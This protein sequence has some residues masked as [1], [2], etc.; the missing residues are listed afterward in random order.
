ME[1]RLGVRENS[2]FDSGAKGRRGAIETY[3]DNQ[4]ESKT[5]SKDKKPKSGE[6]SEFEREENPETEEQSSGL[7][8]S[9]TKDSLEQKDPREDS[10]DP[11]ALTLDRYLNPANRMFGINDGLK[12]NFG[13]SKFDFLPKTGSR[14]LDPV[15]KAE[16]QRLNDAHDADFQQM[17]QPRNLTPS[18]AG[19]FDPINSAKDQTRQESNPFQSF[20]VGINPSL[21]KSSLSPLQPSISASPLLVRPPSEVNLAESIGNR[22]LIP[23]VS[24]SLIAPPVTS[25]FKTAPNPFVLEF[26]KRKF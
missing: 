6:D 5:K 1:E 3:W 18:I 22:A 4:E 23:S 8:E 14:D 26:P 11:T 16:K 7:L 10:K 24:G 13:M 12:E 20:S 2:I 15:Q 9:T 21:G 25:T 17:I 19:A